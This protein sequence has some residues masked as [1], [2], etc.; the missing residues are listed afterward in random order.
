MS[1]KA[2]LE[3]ELRKREKELAVK[4]QQLEGHR[5]ISSGLIVERDAANRRVAQMSAHTREIHHPV[6][7][8]EKRTIQYQEDPN[9]AG[10]RLTK[11]TDTDIDLTQQMGSICCPYCRGTFPVL[12]GAAPDVMKD[13]KK[14]GIIKV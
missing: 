8:V 3:K 1:T 2:E 9:G 6:K 13:L 4:D 11:L 5:R 7:W 12:V 14:Q 10:M